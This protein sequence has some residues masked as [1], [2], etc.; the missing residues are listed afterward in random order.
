MT[1]AEKKFN[2]G[3]TYLLV[4]M[5]FQLLILALLSTM[6]SFGQSNES[7][8]LAAG[9]KKGHDFGKILQGRPVT[10]TFELTNTT[11]EVIR[12]ENVQASCGCTTPVWSY[13]PVQPGATTLLKVGYNA[14]AEGRFEKVVTIIYNSGKTKALTISGE[15]YKAPV[16]SAPINNSI[17]QIKQQ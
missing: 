1:L 11:K 3:E 2:F 8:L 4:F 10:F 16:S 7:D 17:Q 13:D 9:G 6:I 15:V 5:K 14:A 12:I